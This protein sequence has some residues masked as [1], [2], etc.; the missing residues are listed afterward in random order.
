MSNSTN[1]MQSALPLV[2]RVL[3][4]ILFILSGLFKLAEPAGTQGYIA[5]AGV[6]APL[7]AYL[8]AVV[9]ELGGGVLLLV[10]YRVRLA[11][12][13]LAIFTVAAAL[14]FHH[15]IGDQNQFIHFMKNLA[16]TGGLLQV[17]AFGAG[18]FSVDQ[19]RAPVSA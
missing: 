1:N 11:A 13:A 15:A 18:S 4:A 19:R 14:L 10:G 3:L 12:T 9:V 8:V 7:L 16:I 2:G 17:I 5:S 6:P